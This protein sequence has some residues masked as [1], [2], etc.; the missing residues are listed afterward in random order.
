[1]TSKWVFQVKEHGRCKARLVARGFEQKT[2]TDYENLYSPV[3]NSATLRIL[4][5]VAV[6]NGWNFIKF[7][8]KTAF[9]YGELKEEIYTKL[10]EGYEKEKN[11]ICK[12]KKTL[13]GLKQASDCWNT[14]FTE[15]LKKHG[16]KQLDTEK[17]VFKREDNSAILA[18]HVDNGILFGKN[19]QELENLVRKLENYFDITL[20][21]NPNIFLGLE[22]ERGKG[23]SIKLKQ[24]KYL[25]KVLETYT[26][27]EA[28]AMDTPILTN[29]GEEGEGKRTTFPYR[30]AIGSLLYLTT[31]T[32]PDVFSIKRTM[33][34]LQGT[35]HLG[36]VYKK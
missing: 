17:C 3:V 34:Y 23:Q 11:K 15:T 4:F 25:N 35:R 16:F 7:D 9:L 19:K 6:Q 12:L 26:M 31:K 5:A 13:Y 20:D 22:I 1:M 24:A 28:K 29:I 27:G 14:K 18:I 36:I 2:D 30:E 8:V 32:R 10:L 21:N 33:T